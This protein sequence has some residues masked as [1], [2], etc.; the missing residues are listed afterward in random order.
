MLADHAPL[1]ANRPSSR[2]APTR[3]LRSRARATASCG[4]PGIHLPEA[5]GWCRG[6]GA[7]RPVPSPA[8]LPLRDW[9]RIVV[10]LPTTQATRARPAHR[11]P[12]LG[13][14]LQV[15]VTP[16]GFWAWVR[17][18]V[19]EWPSLLKAL[20]CSRAAERSHAI[21]TVLPRR[22]VSGRCT[23]HA[24][25]PVGDRYEGGAVQ[26]SARVVETFDVPTAGA[27][28]ARGGPPDPPAPRRRV[29]QRAIE[30][31]GIVLGVALIATVARSRG[32]SNDEFWSLAAGQ[33]MVAH[34][35]FMG[36]DPFSYTESHRRWVT[37]EWGSEVALAELFR[38]F[39]NAA[40]TLY[41]VLLGGLCLVIS[42]AYARAL[43][44][45]GGRVAAIVLLLAAAIAGTVAGD[46]GLDFSLV[47]LPLEFLALT[48][49]RTDP[50]WL[51]LLPPLCL[52]WVNTHGSILLGSGRP[53]S[54]AGVV[55]DPGALRRRGR[56]SAPVALHRLARTGPAGQR[57]R[58][59]H[60]ALRARPPGLRL[61]RLAQRP[62]RAVHQRVELTGLPFGDDAARLL[63]PAGRARRVR[64]D[65]SGPPAGGHAGRPALRG[66]AADPTSRRVPHGGRGRAGRHA[67]LPGALGDDG[68]ALGGRGAGGARRRHPGHPAG[69]GRVRGL[70]ATG[71]RLRL[72]AARTPGGSSREYTWGD[73]SVARH[74][75]TFVDG[76]TDLFEG[77]VLTEF[78]DVTNLTRT[79]TP[80]CP[81]TTSP[82]SSGPPARRLALYLVRD[83]RWHVVDRTPVAL[84]FARR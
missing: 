24:G 18:I 49:A 7:A 69:A 44:A 61:R 43:G 32:L 62:D 70:V 72:S 64:V 47:W 71:R 75:A 78:I 25:M 48:K 2:R 19:Y 1:A 68:T 77:R 35:A 79:P 65:E 80:C 21:A 22:R 27:A 8:W 84:V 14:V 73:Y 9:H 37:D 46:R 56:R 57:D 10:V 58:L 23:V 20:C 39:G 15:G 83:P 66:G 51:L 54:R 55:A 59:V 74:R 50:R 3:G 26:A 5:H 82:M 31:V 17:G 42:A 81:P 40:Y 34:H 53:G 6:R 33:W 45:R 4:R 28:P 63:R 30:I 12:L 60:H 41:A 36:L 67:A 29:P 76:R 13:R 11:A 38:G 16:P 52:V